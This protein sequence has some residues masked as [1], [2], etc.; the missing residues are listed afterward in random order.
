MNNLTP[1][2]KWLNKKIRIVEIFQDRSI[3]SNNTSDTQDK[4]TILNLPKQVP[5]LLM[6]FTL[7]FESIHLNVEEST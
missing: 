5:K 2:T 3:F 1:V 6:N 4:N 7:N